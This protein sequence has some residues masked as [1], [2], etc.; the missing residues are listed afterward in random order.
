MDLSKLS[1][2]KMKEL[3]TQFNNYPYVM[4][5]N[6]L[7]LNT[8]QVDWRDYSTMKYLTCVN[9]PFARYLTKNPWDRGLHFIQGPNGIDAMLDDECKCGFTDLRVVIEN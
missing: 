1:D 3:F 7:P 2:E 9:H 4:E 5:A 8:D 6:M